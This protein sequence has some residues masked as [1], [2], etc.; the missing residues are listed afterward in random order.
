M[1]NAANVR[2]RVIEPLPAKRDGDRHAPRSDFIPLVVKRELFSVPRGRPRRWNPRFRRTAPRTAGSLHT[3]GGASRTRAGRSRR[4]MSYTHFAALPEFHVSQKKPQR[5]GRRTEEIA[6]RQSPEA[7]PERECAPAGGR[8]GRSGSVG[9]AT[10]TIGNTRSGKIRRRRARRRRGA[11]RRG[12]S[13]GSCAPRSSCSGGTPAARSSYCP[14][15][16]SIGG[17]PSARSSRWGGAGERAGAI[18]GTR[19]RTAGRRAAIPCR[20][21]A[22]G[23]WRTR[24]REEEV[25]HRPNSVTPT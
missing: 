17:T 12:R 14:L 19:R 15:A 16:T 13:P 21:D 3:R 6:G 25:F 7:I 22:G 23:R 1:Q 10:Q 24:G 9:G 8:R 5:R 18:R 2:F 4:G 20:Q 11:G